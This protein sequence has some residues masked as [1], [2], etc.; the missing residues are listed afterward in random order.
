MYSHGADF[1]LLQASENCKSASYVRP[2]YSSRTG[3]MFLCEAACGRMHAI[4]RDDS[5]LR[6]APAGYD[7]VKVRGRGVCLFGGRFD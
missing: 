5:S 2:D 4:T 1:A 3:I 7:S 6:A